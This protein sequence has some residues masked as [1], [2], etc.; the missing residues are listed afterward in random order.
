[1]SATLSLSRAIPDGYSLYVREVPQSG[2]RSRPIYF[3][4]KTTPM[5]GQ[6]ATVPEGYRV[7]QRATGPRLERAYRS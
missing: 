1:M 3:F 7:V 2:G 4:S 5:S 6:P